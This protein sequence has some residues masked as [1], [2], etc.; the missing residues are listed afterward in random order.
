MRIVR[1]AGRALAVG[2]VV[3]ALCLFPLLNA[4]TSAPVWLHWIWQDSLDCVLAWAFAACLVAITVGVPAFWRRRVLRDAVIAL[5]LLLSAM[6]V[7]GALVKVGVLV[8]YI[9]AHR[10]AGTGVVLLSALILAGAAVVL[11]RHP[12][13]GSRVETVAIRLW[14]A[15]LLLLFDLTRAPGLAERQV[16]LR[17]P[18]PSSAVSARVPPQ[19]IATLGQRTV[20]L[21]FDELSPDYLYGSRA[22]ALSGYPALSE[23]V[24]RGQVHLGARLHGGATEFAI[25]ALFGNTDSAPR[26]LVPSLRSQGESVR[27]WGWYHDYCAGMAAAADVCHANS[28][29]N[30]RTL[31]EVP[32][33]IAPWWTD[34]NLLP[35]VFPFSLVKTPTAVALHRH[36]L[37]ATQHW[38]AAQ[39]ADPGADV[40]YAHVNVPH[41]PLI[42]ATAVEATAHPFTMTEAGY[43][44]QF[45]AIDKVIGQVLASRTRPTQLIVL[46]DHNARPLFPKPEHEHVVF[47]R[48][49]S[50]VSRAAAVP[51]PEDAAELVG[52]MS[53]SPE[54]P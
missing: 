28:I 4:L 5:W 29:Y 24:D 40:I 14:P 13:P 11:V 43:L 21:L 30:P 36:T 7:S 26:G 39:L 27:V 25:P 12:G 34:L 22:V 19:A 44:T 9:S 32:A 37:A 1:E 16:A 45:A 31:N 51:T 23:L 2:A 46:S 20:I 10:S 6:F 18:A 33:W 52:R 42:D 17:S 54:S 41:L 35:A 8:A 38:L 49:R 3:A 15:I 50:W 48:W 53:L 47:I